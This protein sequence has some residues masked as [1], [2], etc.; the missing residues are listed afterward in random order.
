MNKIAGKKQLLLCF[1][2]G[3]LAGVLYSNFVCRDELAM[4]GIFSPYFLSMYSQ[5]DIVFARLAMQVLKVRVLPLGILLLGNWA[6]Q[7]KAAVVGVLLWTGFCCGMI[8]VSAVIQLGASGI[9]LSI[10]T[11]FPHFLFYVIAYSVLL[12]YEYDYPQNQWNIS[13]T[14]FF[15]SMLAVGIIMELYVSPV[16]LRIFLN[17]I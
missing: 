4:N 7:R 17:I 12:I 6:N 8:F 11:L 5:T 3:L 16:F 9:L 13:K 10:L 1:F 15:V 14:T 2:A